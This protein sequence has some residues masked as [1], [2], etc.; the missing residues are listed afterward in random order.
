MVPVTQAYSQNSVLPTG[1][2]IAKVTQ[3]Y[4]LASDPMATTCC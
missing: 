2:I 4:G 3:A 1:K